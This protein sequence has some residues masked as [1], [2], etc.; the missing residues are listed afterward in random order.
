MDQY[1]VVKVIGEGS[2]GRAHLVQLK[3]DKVKWVMKEIR[4]HKVI[5]ADILI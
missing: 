2:F 4:L 3:T 5:F 1:T